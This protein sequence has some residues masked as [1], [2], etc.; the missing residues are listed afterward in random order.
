MYEDRKK[1]AFPFQTHV[2]INMI[3]EHQK[4]AIK[5]FRIMERSVLSGK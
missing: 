1:W 2:A 3:K 5:P 4:P